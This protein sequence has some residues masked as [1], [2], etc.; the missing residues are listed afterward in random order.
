MNQ[1]QPNKKTIISFLI[2][3]LLASWFILHPFTNFD[4]QIGQGDNG[5]D[6]YAYQQ[7][8]HGAAPYKDYWWVY[9]PL[10]PYYYGAMIN[11][12]GP[13]I[14]S[15]FLGKILLQVI[16]GV[17]IYFIILHF[18]PPLFAMTAAIWFWVFNPSFS[19]TYN[20]VGGVTFLLAIILLAIKYIHQKKRVYIWSGII[21]SY[22]L[23]LIKVNIGLAA[24]G[25]FGL[26]ILSFDFFQNR[27][28]FKNNF[29]I[30][31]ISSLSLAGALLETYGFFLRGLPVYSIKQCLP[32]MSEDNP[33]HASVFQ[34]FPMY[35]WI[36]IRNVFAA[37]TNMILALFINLSFI[38]TMRILLKRNLGRDQTNKL[39]FSLIALAIF[40]LSALH[41]F[42]TSGVPYRLFWASSIQFM[43]IFIFLSVGTTAIK[44]AIRNLLMIALLCLGTYYTL[45]IHQFI[46]LFKVPSQFL[47]QRSGQI[48]VQNQ[49]EWMDTVNST[50]KFLNDNLKNDESFF[51]LPYDP[52][53]YYLT[54]RKSP[55][56][57][58]IFF[59]HI[60][61]PP[62]QE[63]T[64]IAELEKANTRYIV[65][66]N[67]SEA[68]LDSLGHFGK[69]YCPLLYAYIFE[70]YSPVA[71]FGDWEKP[72]EAVFNHA[73]KIYK[74]H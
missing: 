29:L 1:P 70:N 68:Y 41:E 37:P 59:K 58:L 44:P 57:Q 2:L 63:K 27:S 56:R 4:V 72:A 46:K 39:F 8:A 40:L 17:I 6:Y 35:A 11:I 55:T 7:T 16:G 34:T 25:A 28:A 48:Y 69:D 53:Y 43:F 32:Y 33:T 13:T 67:R 71:A 36:N 19:Y 47:S 26:S 20:H 66:S 50:V 9:G 54:E 65:I 14:K 18:G 30:F 52:L 23:S 60:N 42:L 74:K 22:F 5:R 61:I 73:V 64:I 15:I 31:F 49:P 62:Q 51:A 21:L 12:V 38:Q 24:F 10:M 45:S 3:A